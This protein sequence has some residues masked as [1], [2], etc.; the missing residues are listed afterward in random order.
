MAQTTIGR[1]RFD[2]ETL[3]TMADNLVLESHESPVG[4]LRAMLEL[5]NTHSE[6]VLVIQAFRE[7]V[8]VGFIVA[9]IEPGYVWI[10][11]AWSHKSNNERVIDALF[12]RVKLWALGCGYR[13]IRA[14]TRRNLE[15][16]RERFDFKP[17][18]TTIEHTIGPEVSEAVM[19]VLNG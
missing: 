16:M 6:R 13:A 7:N 4:F 8:L 14:E 2:D 9:Q 17:V 19:G 1:N 5:Y 3:R 12:A 18:S 10:S 15:A 11:Q